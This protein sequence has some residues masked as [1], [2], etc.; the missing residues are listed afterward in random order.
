MPWLE[1]NGYESMVEVKKKARWGEFKKILKDEFI[2]QPGAKGAGFPGD[3][4]EKMIRAVIILP[5]ERLFRQEQGLIAFH[6]KHQP[7]DR[8]RIG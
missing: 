2:V 6:G 7:P 5:R 8:F 4:V 3:L 1:A